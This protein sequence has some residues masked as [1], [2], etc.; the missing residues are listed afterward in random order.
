M[1]VEGGLRSDA[2]LSRLKGVHAKLGEDIERGLVEVGQEAK[3]GMQAAVEQATWFWQ[4]LFKVYIPRIVS[5]V[6]DVP[7]PRCAS[8][9]RI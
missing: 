1:K 6:G 9:L 7:I 2:D 5:T 3:T 4:E 8:S